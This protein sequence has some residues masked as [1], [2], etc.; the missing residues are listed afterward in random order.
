MEDIII[1]VSKIDLGFTEVSFDPPV[2]ID[3][4]TLQ[5]FVTYLISA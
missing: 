1:D 3:L 2:R 5:E 4:E